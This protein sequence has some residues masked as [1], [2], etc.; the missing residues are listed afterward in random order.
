M[1]T[2]ER[3]RELLHYAPETGAFTRVASRG[4]R[5]MAGNIAGSIDRQG[6][7]R[8]TIDRR[9]Y[10][11]HRLAWLY[12]TGA[13]PENYIDH[14]N[15]V[16]DDNRFANLREATSGENHQNITRRSDNTSGFIGVTWHRQ[17]MKWMAQI[18]VDGRYHYLGCFNTYEE[19][20]AAYLK[21][22]ADLHT[23]QPV[24]REAA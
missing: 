9:E 3:L 1:L 11:A 2:A 23:F 7:R 8:I 4:G 21:A 6:Y 20:N 19:A 16:R 13:W 14:R 15:G 5:A 18:R 17:N 24:P 10:K 22:K 12:V